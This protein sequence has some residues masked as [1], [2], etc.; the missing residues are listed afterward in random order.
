[1]SAIYGHFNNNYNLKPG[2]KEPVWLKLNDIKR[3]VYPISFVLPIVL[4]QLLDKTFRTLGMAN[5]V[6]VKNQI[7]MIPN[8]YNKHI[9]NNK[10]FKSSWI[11]YVLILGFLI[12]EHFK[13]K[14]AKAFEILFGIQNVSKSVKD[15]L[16]KTL[17]E[18][19]EEYLRSVFGIT[20]RSNAQSGKLHLPM[21]LLY[22]KLAASLM[23]VGN[24][25]NTL[26][27]PLNRTCSFYNRFEYNQ[28]NL[29]KGV[30]ETKHLL[31]F[32]SRFF[33]TFTYRYVV[34][35]ASSNNSLREIVKQIE[36][37]SQFVYIV[38]VYVT[39][40]NILKLIH[41][42]N[43]T[44]QSGFLESTGKQ[45][46]KLIDARDNS[47]V[48]TAIKEHI[49]VSNLDFPEKVKNEYKHKAQT[50]MLKEFVDLPPALLRPLVRGVKVTVNN[51]IT[52]TAKKALPVV[53][54]V[55]Q[56]KKALP[57]IAPVMKLLKQKVKYLRII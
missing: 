14:C 51:P 6:K 42:K 39:F 31:T 1:M 11:D 5:K 8:I 40:L 24:I 12:G 36:N 37:K 18:S 30:K 52:R 34:S 13:Q 26:N 22:L 44:S 9:S 20:Y 43:V 50:I 25:N 23:S 38:S 54:R 33:E 15:M 19:P 16:S 32:L 27:V 2:N 53:K 55:S 3:A 4:N 7:L 45:D 21:L 47:Q 35:G 56:V 57:I 46:I 29:T 28:N 48:L 17:Y 10:N 41:N 49:V